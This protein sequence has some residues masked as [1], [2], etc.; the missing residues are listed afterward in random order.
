MNLF[1]EFLF[2]SC[3]VDYDKDKFVKNYYAVLKDRPDHRIQLSDLSRNYLF[4]PKKYTKKNG[5]LIGIYI[6]ELSR[7]G[8]PVVA[9]DTAKLLFD[10][11]YN[12]AI[13]SIYDGQLKSEI[14]DYGIPVFIMGDIKYYQLLNNGIEYYK[15]KLDMDCLIDAFDINFL[16]TLTLY[17]LINRYMND[18][19]LY[20][21]VHEGSITYDIIGSKLPINITDNVTVLCGGQYSMNQMKKYGFDY[22]PRI[23]N[24]GVTDIG[25]KIVTKKDTN[26]IRFL[27]A[28]SICSRKGQDII[29]KA[30]NKLPSKILDKCEFLFIGDTNLDPNS[31]K[32]EKMIINTSKKHANVKLMASIPRKQL[33]NVYKKTDVLILASTDDPMP[34]VA[35]E[36]LMLG[37]IILCTTDTGTSYYLKNK[38]NG[39]VFETDDVNSLCKLITYIVENADK[40]NDI[41]QNGR[42]VFENEFEMSIFKERLL[43]VLKGDI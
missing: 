29:I 2:R 34:V 22:K 4:T 9:F 15:E 39:F 23:L 41:K 18:Y 7:T 14:L 5:K 16:I 40:L 25:K 27:N 10:E 12:V 19:K 37:N 1:S 8:A 43:N 6:H 35:T 20:W 42:K 36:N 13:I 26:I 31:K 11:G 33:F 38:E 30:I 32:I 24:Y 17:Q 3:F 21:W 28:G